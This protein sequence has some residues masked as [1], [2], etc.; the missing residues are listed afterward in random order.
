[1]TEDGNRTAMPKGMPS[2]R[3]SVLSPNDA[4][5]PGAVGASRRQS[6]AVLGPVVRPPS[7]VL[8]QS[9]LIPPIS[10]AALCKS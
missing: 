3:S 1:M 4:G 7:S 2:L 10:A 6:A 8:Q 5:P 9:L